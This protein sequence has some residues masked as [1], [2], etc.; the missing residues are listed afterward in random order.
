MIYTPDYTEGK[1][2]VIQNNGT[3]REYQTMPD[4][5]RTVQYKDFYTSM[6]YNY[7]VGTTTFSNYS[8]LPTCR[9]ATDNIMYRVDINTLVINTSI[10]I[11]LLL[12][13]LLEYV[14]RLFR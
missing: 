10:A 12:I 6:N 4:Y 1:C 8:T 13:F 11:I 5:G 7:N 3:I 2:V 14:R 9:E